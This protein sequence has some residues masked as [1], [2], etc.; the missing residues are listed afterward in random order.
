[1]RLSPRSFVVLT[2]VAGVVV[3][4]NLIALRI[5]SVGLGLIVDDVAVFILAVFSPNVFM[6][7]H[8]P[9]RDGR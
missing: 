3:A 6:M 1:M 5:V 4:P 2:A 8:V 7:L 9:H